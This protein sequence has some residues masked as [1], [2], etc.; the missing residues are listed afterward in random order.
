MEIT[1]T[2]TVTPEQAAA[3]ANL[4]ANSEMAA[5]SETRANANPM[6]AANAP[7]S[8]TAAF[9]APQ[10]TPNTAPVQSPQALGATA[11]SMVQA[12]AAVPVPHS[13]VV[14]VPV[15]QQMPPV[16]QGIP[17]QVRTY[18]VQ[19]LALACRPLMEAGKQAELQALLVEFGASAGINSIP[20]NRRADFAARLRQ[21]GGQI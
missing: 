17:T 18:S 3:I 7:M 8:T 12:P 20:E 5:K 19:D 11:A 14:G 1:M 21:M 6:P 4:L 15:Q 13:N 10:T 9:T 2:L 16:Q